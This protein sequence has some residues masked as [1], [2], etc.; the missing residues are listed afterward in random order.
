MGSVGVDKSGMAKRCHSHKR[1]TKMIHLNLEISNP[2]SNYFKIGRVFTGSIT[3]NKF[4]ELQFMRTHDILCAK[5]D[6][7]TGQD[8]AGFNIELG[9]LSFSAAFTVY[10]HRHWNY[11]SKDW[12]K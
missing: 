3:K 1:R 11:L 2:W 12:E 4:W 10:D 8:H 5:L 7:T 6:F 9:L